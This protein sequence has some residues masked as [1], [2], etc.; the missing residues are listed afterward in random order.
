MRGEQELLLLLSP[1]RVTVVARARLTS[2]SAR[3]SSLASRAPLAER[4]Y[5]A[6]TW[7][8]CSI[9]YGSVLGTCADSRANCSFTCCIPLPVERR[10][11]DQ[12][13]QA[14]LICANDAGGG[15]TDL[16]RLSWRERLRA[17]RACDPRSSAAGAARTSPA[18]HR[19]PAVRR[20]PATDSSRGSSK[21]S[22]CCC[23]V[24]KS[25]SSGAIRTSSASAARWASIFSSV[26][27]ATSAFASHS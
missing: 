27:G 9:T 24:F 16:G 17:R 12:S 21:G 1:R 26:T 15:S 23:Q 11:V 2:H 19:P 7:L 3:L 20:S 22:S 10:P 18:A 5:S 8:L 4:T 14:R 13:F 6:V 25:A